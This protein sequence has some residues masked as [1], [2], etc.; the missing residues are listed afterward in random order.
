MARGCLTTMRQRTLNRT[1]LL[2]LLLAPG[3]GCTF[4]TK[5]GR[6]AQC[7]A[8]SDCS[9]CQR[10]SDGQC[11]ADSSDPACA[12][13]RPATGSGPADAGA[14]FRAGSGLDAALAV[15][16][17]T[18]EVGDAGFV[19]LQDGGTPP[20][21]QIFGPG[22]NL[23]PSPYA[24]VLDWHLGQPMPTAR[25]APAVAAVN[26]RVYVFGGSDDALHTLSAVEIY[27][28]SADAWRKPG[29][30]MPTDREGASAAVGPD[31]RIYVVGGVRARFSNGTRYE[32]PALAVEIYDP[33][34]D[35]WST[36]EISPVPVTPN[37]ASSDLSVS[38]AFLGAVLAVHVATDFMPE[39][40]AI[41]VSAASPGWT[42][43]ASTLSFAGGTT[44]VAAGRWLLAM[45]NY[46]TDFGRFGES[47]AVTG[48]NLFDWSVSQG[49]EQESANKRY[50]TVLVAA[51]GFPDTVYA[52]GGFAV[53]PDQGTQ[54]LSCVARFDPDDQWASANVLLVP[55]HRLG[56]ASADGRI[57]AIGGSTCSTFACKDG[58]TDAVEVATLRN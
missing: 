51:G 17:S 38:G 43:S 21:G 1:L 45:E 42:C 41:D 7:F 58:A 39:D 53:G 15:D 40:C 19:W 33:R 28:P 54:V 22:C 10:C 12:T 25:S 31:G 34:A 14:N 52:L 18:P 3:E 48:G 27:D 26:G 8:T 30:P 35:S 13:T 46:P 24:P 32:D 2:A 37:G 20:S 11:V 49:L 9:G 23:P 5:P 29:A 16:G 36:R 4:S 47:F 56:V 6:L 55:R 50:G 44:M 57:F